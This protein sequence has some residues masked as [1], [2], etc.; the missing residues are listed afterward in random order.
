[1]KKVK[2]KYTCPCG[3]SYILRGTYHG[4]DSIETGFKQCLCGN[5][6]LD[7][8]QLDILEVQQKRR[9]VG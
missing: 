8:F 9:V 3:Q 2:V 7:T 6:D 5:K 1:M 4:K